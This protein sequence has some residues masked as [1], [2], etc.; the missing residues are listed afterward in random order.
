M[1][2]ALLETILGSMK[3][4]HFC[5]ISHSKK[6][7]GGWPKIQEFFFKTKKCIIIIIIFFLSHLYFDVTMNLRNCHLYCTKKTVFEQNFFLYTFH[8]YHK[9]RKGITLGIIKSHIV[10]KNMLLLNNF[11]YLFY[12]FFFTFNGKRWKKFAREN[13]K[14]LKKYRLHIKKIVFP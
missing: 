1:K 5:H 10:P 11:L 7:G 6:R 8:N 2:R 14:V 13:E 12:I 4:L 3:K 9:R